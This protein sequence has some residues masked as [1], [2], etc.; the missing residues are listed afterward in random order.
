MKPAIIL[1]RPQIGDNIGAVARIMKNFSLQD[2]RIVSPRDGWPNK[3]AEIVSMG[4]IDIIRNAKIFDKIEDAICDLQNIFACSARRRKVNKEYYN[5]K[6]HVKEVREKKY[7]KIGIMFGSEKY[8]LFNE[9]LVLAKKVVAISANEEYPILNLS[10]A[11]SLICYEYYNIGDVHD[12]KTKYKDKQIDAEQM[13]FY[14]HDLQ[15]KLGQT[16]FFIDG[17][18]QKKMFQAISNIYTRMDLSGQ[19]VKSL[20][21]INQALFY[22]RKKDKKKNN[23]KIS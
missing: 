4:G 16:D 20:I 11:V 2:L 12:I 15:E 3:K 10:H 14:L 8:G 18:R 17:A 19:E 1:S 7:K 6:D 5:L 9:E 21:G 23:I 22:K 13:N